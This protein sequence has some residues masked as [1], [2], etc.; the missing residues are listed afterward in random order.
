MKA[1]EES[2]EFWANVLWWAVLLL[3]FFFLLW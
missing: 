3:A 2:N 1:S